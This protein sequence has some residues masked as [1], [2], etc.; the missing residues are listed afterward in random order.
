MVGE[1]SPYGL[2]ICALGAIVLAGSVY[3]PW[4]APSVPA[5][6]HASAAGAAGRQA[7]ALSAHHAL[8][9]LSVVLPVL[10]GLALLDS[11]IPLARAAT[12]VPAGGGAS[13][14]LL[15]S[16]AAVC[17]LYRIVHPPA[18]AGGAALAL[19]PRE[20]AW[21][22]LLGALAM[23]AGGLWPRSTRPPEQSEPL[24]LGARPGIAG[25]T[26]GNAD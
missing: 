3:L 18:L 14:L 26:R 5:V 4:Y 8:A 20:G 24:A 6:A 19:S 7:A 17:V 2:L 16:V 10:A 21:L 13:V 9:D 11:L 23:V 22:A 25:W 15:G 1:R 12:P